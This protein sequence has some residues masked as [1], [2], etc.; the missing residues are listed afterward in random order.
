MSL[1]N[2]IKGGAGAVRS[3]ALDVATTFGHSFLN[4]LAPDDFEFYA[5]SFELLNGRGDTAAYMLFPVMPNNISESKSEIITI[6][7][8]QSSVVTQFSSGFCPIDINL[9]G[10][11][12]KK[13]RLISGLK[14]VDKPKKGKFS[15]NL[16]IN[17]GGLGVAV[18]TGYGM[19]KVMKDIIDALYKK[20]ENGMP[21]TLIFSNHSLGTEYVV[22]VSN[23]SFNQSVENNMIW[24]YSLDMKAVAPASTL[25]Q[26]S[27]RRFI[28]RTNLQSLGRGVENI[29]RKTTKFDLSSMFG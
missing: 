26:D 16:G 1:S 18:K 9:Q 23:S 11:F 2:F 7:K 28:V 12:G 15:L 13:F 24:F 10:T 29:V 20:D 4:V 17:L 25:I 8:T 6:T 14:T 22:E 27:D 21:Y 19:T 3:S 5:C